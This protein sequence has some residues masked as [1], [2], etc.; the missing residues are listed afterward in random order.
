MTA[1]GGMLRD[2]VAP[3][4]AAAEAGTVRLTG[5]DDVAKAASRLLHF[6]FAMQCRGEAVS[7]KQNFANDA[8]AS[9]SILLHPL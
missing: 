9:V 5:T 6:A 8:S 4:M 3:D 2:Q 1:N 7:I